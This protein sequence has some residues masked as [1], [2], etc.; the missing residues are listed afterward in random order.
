MK[1]VLDLHTVSGF[2]LH[3]GTGSHNKSRR[4][5][6]L[7]IGDFSRLSHVSPRMLRYYDT[8]G[9]LCPESIGE[10]GYRY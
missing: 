1:K 8:M 4:D 7:T 3:T 5:V 9:L 10:N 6:M 2:I